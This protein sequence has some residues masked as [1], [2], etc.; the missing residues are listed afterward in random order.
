MARNV[1]QTGFCRCVR[2]RASRTQARL[3]TLERAVIRTYRR[4]SSSTFF[5]LFA[6]MNE[7]NKVSVKTNKKNPTEMH[8]VLNFFF[9]IVKS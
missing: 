7:M 2:R 8:D 1:K 5:R 3:L 9:L 4:R 6:G